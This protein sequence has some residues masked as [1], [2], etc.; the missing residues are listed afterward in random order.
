MQWQNGSILVEAGSSC[1]ENLCG[2][3]WWDNHDFAAR[4]GPLDQRLAKQA[5]KQ[6]QRPVS[7]APF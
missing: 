7:R 1:A 6:K 5:P 3:V 2:L 4:R